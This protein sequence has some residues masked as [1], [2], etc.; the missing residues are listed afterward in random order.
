MRPVVMHRQRRWRWVAEWRAPSCRTTSEGDP[1]ASGTFVAHSSAMSEYCRVRRLAFVQMQTDS[2]GMPNEW[3][4]EL[5]EF[6]W[7]DFVSVCTESTG[8][9]V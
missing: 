1:F 4:R 7:M 5:L 6:A 2:C 9:S 3:V 8:C